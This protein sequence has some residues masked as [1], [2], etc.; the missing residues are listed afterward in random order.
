MV[1][2][3]VGF[4]VTSFGRERLVSAVKQRFKSEIH[5]SSI[6]LRLL[7][8]TIT[9]D[10][11]VFRHKDRRD[12]P[13]LVQLRRA[14]VRLGVTSLPFLLWSTPR[15]SGVYLEQLEVTVAR[16]K[17]AREREQQPREKSKDKTPPPS[18]VIQ[19]LVADGTTLRVLPKKEGK[20]PLQFDLKSLRM[21]SV[22]LE[23]PM[24]FVATLTNAKPP[25]LI[26]TKGQ[27]GPWH[28]DEPGLTPV[29]GTYT[30]ENANLSDFDGIE[31][32]LSSQG[33]YEGE[34]ERIIVDGH[35][36]TPDFMVDAGE[37]RVHLKT[38]F[39]AIVD[40]TNG[41]TLL[42]PVEATWGNSK[43]VARGGVYGIE[44]IKGKTVRLDV[45]VDRGRIEDMLKFAVKSKEPILRG[46]IR[47]EASLEIPPGKGKVVHKLNLDGVFKV[48]Q[49]SFG[50]ANVRQKI[51]SFS[52][53]G[54]GQPEAPVPEDTASDFGGRFH[55]DQGLLRLS[56]LSFRVPGAQVRLAG[57]YELLSEMLD[58]NG[59]LMLDSKV[60]ETTT[61]LK[62][63]FLKLA[64]PL[65]S[66]KG[67][68]SEVPIR[69]TG[70]RKDPK[71][72]LDAAEVFKP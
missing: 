5:F 29:R 58:F 55:L 72:N 42:Q 70:R 41:D 15:V 35:T 1:I 9:I 38:T 23:R 53:R 57:S 51:G 50:S 71:F 20:E 6:H 27:F 36:D 54:K 33:R 12:V 18:F 49:G 48:T 4:P 24:D 34:L 64:D 47:Y 13:P 19:N 26:R 61:G 32:T 63:L 59:V 65:F 45:D 17:D 25:G 7:P 46:P 56:D 40:G 30:F 10:D 62:S 21:N 52:N 31:G 69:I 11:V 28:D 67:G 3:A 14:R 22:S 39:H 8:V 37:Q 43:V 16:K 60:S 68:R 2:A 66:R 44:G